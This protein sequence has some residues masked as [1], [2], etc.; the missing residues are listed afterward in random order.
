MNKPVVETESDKSIVYV[1]IA[2]YRARIW[3]DSC[4]K[5]R[6]SYVLFLFPVHFHE[7]HLT[8]RTIIGCQTFVKPYSSREPEERQYNLWQL[9]GTSKENLDIHHYIL[10]HSNLFAF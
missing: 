6:T 1:V 2:F 8:G 3:T 7:E 10:R 4:F 5:I 9:D